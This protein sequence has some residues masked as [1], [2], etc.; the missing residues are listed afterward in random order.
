MKVFASLLMV[1]FLGLAVAP[2]CRAQFRERRGSS[3]QAGYNEGRSDGARDARRGR[4]WD[5]DSRA[6]RGSSYERGYRDGYRD[7]YRAAKPSFVIPGSGF[8]TRPVVTT[9]PI[10]VGHP[11]QGVAPVTVVQ[12]ANV[13]AGTAQLTIV[14]RTSHGLTITGR[15]DSH[16]RDELVQFGRVERGS[17]TT[18]AIKGGRWTLWGRNRAGRQWQISTY[19]DRGGQFTQYFTN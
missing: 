11:G 14:N 2:E 9:R 1:M 8:V 10:L 3:F 4:G 18:F 6:R 16:G 15:R 7:G 12:P 17:S 19:I 5:P 13:F